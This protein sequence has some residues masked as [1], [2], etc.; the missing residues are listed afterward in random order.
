[1]LHDRAT[2]VYP[3]L[4]NIELMKGNY[5]FKFGPSTS[6]MLDKL[7]KVTAEPLTYY[8][9]KRRDLEQKIDKIAINQIRIAKIVNEVT[10]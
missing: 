5:E 8:L 7:K 4:R 6:T 3:A 9:Y 10:L 2:D 1:M